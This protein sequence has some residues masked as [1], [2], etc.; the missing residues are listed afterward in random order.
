VPGSSFEDLYLVNPTHVRPATPDE[1]AVLEAE[2]GVRM[3]A[4]YGEYVQRVGEGALGHFV[5]VHAPA[6]LPDR[7]LE[8][9][10]R[11]Q[12]YWFWDTSEAGVSPEALQQQGVLV[13]DTFDGDELCFHPADPG[14][15][16]VLPRNEDV[17]R[18]LGPGLVTAVDWMLSG[19]LN[20]WVEGWSFETST[21]RVE[22]RQE[23]TPG[24]AL[25]AAAQALA[26]LGEH[27]HVVE[28]ADRQTF[29]LPV[30]G[31]RLSLYQPEDEPLAMDLTYDADADPDA[32]RRLLAVLG[33]G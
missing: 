10:K 20:P 12:E 32:V 7:T 18:R 11:I 14:A 22:V 24:L 16:F 26:D 6:G 33:A 31:G 2:L 4:G 19:A 27:S 3:P 30:I 28:L 8:W 17:A 29:F 23:P 5:V 9:R 13:A 21:H 25:D 1:V 15:L